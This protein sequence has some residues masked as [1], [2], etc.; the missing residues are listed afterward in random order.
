MCKIVQGLLI[1]IFLCFVVSICNCVHIY[2]VY[3][4][5][6]QYAGPLFEFEKVTRVAEDLERRW[7]FM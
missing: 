3:L 6:R 2:T 7:L 5:L 1:T 4:I